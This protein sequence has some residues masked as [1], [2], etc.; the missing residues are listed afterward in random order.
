MRN[1]EKTSRNS[2]NRSGEAAFWAERET[3]QGLVASL[4]AVF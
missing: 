3:L 4:Q 1:D 2:N